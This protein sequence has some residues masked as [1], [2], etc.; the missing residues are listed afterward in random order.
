MFYYETKLFEQ[1]CYYIII[2]KKT[3]VRNMKQFALKNEETIINKRNDKNRNF[4]IFKT[5]FKNIKKQ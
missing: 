5:F 3:A 4:K 1:I 2:T